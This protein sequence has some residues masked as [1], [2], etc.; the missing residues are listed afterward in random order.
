MPSITELISS[1]NLDNLTGAGVFNFAILVLWCIVAGFFAQKLVD[2]T[3][4]S[5]LV[6][7]CVIVVSLY[8]WLLVAWF[9]NDMDSR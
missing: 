6:W 5:A 7:G 3:A 4:L 8:G 2:G 1:L 9:S